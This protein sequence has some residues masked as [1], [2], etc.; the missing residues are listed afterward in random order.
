[1][2]RCYTARVAAPR[3]L[4]ALGGSLLL[5][6]VPSA[7]PSAQP[8][9]SL[10]RR[11]IDSPGVTLQAPSGKLALG[12]F[13][14]QM[15]ARQP[16]LDRATKRVVLDDWRLGADVERDNVSVTCDIR[17]PGTGTAQKLAGWILGEGRPGGIPYESIGGKL[18]VSPRLQ[19]QCWSRA[20]AWTPALSAAASGHTPAGQETIDGRP[21]DRYKV[22]A[23][24]TALE[25]LRPMMN[26]TSARGTVWLDR[27]TGALLK[28]TL[29]YKEMFTEG[30][31]SG[32]VLGAADG[33]VEMTV[34]RVG[35]V[36]VK[37]PQ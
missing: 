10:E 26:L 9:P 29:A 23:T 31:G 2:H 20:Y 15:K 18:D 34:T 36:T 30:R 22:E 1:M 35:K 3:T 7:P 16:R 11:I 8:G 5:L 14:L 4:V 17:E 28:T 21:A 33:R 6:A 25:R 27:Q 12:S 24:P 32:T 37:P 19:H 13:H